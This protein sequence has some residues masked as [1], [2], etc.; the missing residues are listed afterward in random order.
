M[1]HHVQEKPQREGSTT[2]ETGENTGKYVRE[3]GERKT[4]LT[5]PLRFVKT[6][7]FLKKHKTPARLD[8]I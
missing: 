1:N 5:I 2:T 3:L 8:Y 6:I 7:T 4:T